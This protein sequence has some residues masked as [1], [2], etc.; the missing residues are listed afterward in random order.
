MMMWGRISRP[1]GPFRRRREEVALSFVRSR[2]SRLSIAWP[3]GVDDL[4]RW[5]GIGLGW[6]QRFGNQVE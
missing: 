2:H 5:L 1:S 3:R 6:R 4:V